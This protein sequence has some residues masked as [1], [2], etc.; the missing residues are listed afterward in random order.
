MYNEYR[1]NK[2]PF[3]YWYER[4]S[5][6]EK[7]AESQ[8]LNKSEDNITP[9][10]YAEYIKNRILASGGNSLELKR[11]YAVEFP[12]LEEVMLYVTPVENGKSDTLDNLNNKKYQAAYERYLKKAENVNK[13]TVN[14]NT[15][16]NTVLPVINKI[17]KN[18]K[19]VN[20]D[21]F[22][23]FIDGDMSGAE[24]V[25]EYADSAAAMGGPAA[26][27]V[28][29]IYDKIFFSLPSLAN[30]WK[31]S[32]IEDELKKDGLLGKED[33]E[34]IDINEILDTAAE[35]AIEALADS[36]DFVSI[37]TKAS[38]I[39]R[40]LYVSAGKKASE[41]AKKEVVKDAVSEVGEKALKKEANNLIEKT[42][43]NIHPNGIYE[44]ASYHGVKNNYIKNKAP[45]KGQEAL[46]NSIPIKDETTRR[47]GV[48]DGEIVIFDETTKGIFHGH[49]RLWSE[50]TNKM[51][52]V[53]KKAG[54]V[55]KKGK[56]IN[57]E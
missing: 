46:D 55:N 41:E 3:S 50:L 4:E 24:K 10:A 8:E 6:S 12:Y 48:S 27:L 47:I 49:V 15:F 11:K 56:I 7:T 1:E 52:A 2:K 37:D 25:S 21:V 28:K 51:K 31:N 18:R 30:S 32:L 26:V 44:K 40:N 39:S 35:A 23:Y 19:E 43:E 42:I 29:K 20:A 33:S 22:E 16:L 17:R 36:M 13:K 14:Y 54:L 34:S 38:E 45:N 9:A 57:G 53:L 5:E